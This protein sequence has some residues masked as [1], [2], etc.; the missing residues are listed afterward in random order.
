MIVQ[1]KVRLYI[2]CPGCTEG[3]WRVDQLSPGQ[4]TSWTCES[5]R[6][7]C[8]ILRVDANFFKV[9]LNGRKDTPV[10]VTLRS[11]T[12]PAITM[13]LNAWKYSHSQKDSPEEYK[14]HQRYFYDEHTCPSNWVKYVEEISVGKDK[15]PH[16]IFGF[17]SVEDGTLVDSK[18]GGGMVVKKS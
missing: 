1:A 15:D 5:C 7:E 11:D 6:N 18:Y 17:V 2:P 8:D 13:R 4:S 3:S 9:A 12:E 14:E 16:G 10:V